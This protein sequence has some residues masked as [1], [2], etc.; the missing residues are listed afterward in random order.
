MIWLL[1]ALVEG[2]YGRRPPL[3]EVRHHRPRFRRAIPRNMCALRN[4]AL[5]R[6]PDL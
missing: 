6:R 2:L 1:R 4:I 5:T 3:G